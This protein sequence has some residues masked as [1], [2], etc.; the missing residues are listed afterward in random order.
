MQLHKLEYLKCPDCPTSKMIYAQNAF[1]CSSCSKVFGIDNEK[2]SFVNFTGSLTYDSLDAVKSFFKKYPQLYVFLR[3]FFAPVFFERDLHN[4]V[5]ENNPSEKVVVH[6]GS[7]NTRFHKDILNL[8]IIGYGNVNIIADITKIPLQSGSVDAVILDSVLEHV[9]QPDVVTKEVLRILK[10]QGNL[11]VSIPFMMGFHACPDDYYRWTEEGAKILLQ[12][13]KILKLKA[14]G[15]PTSAL[16]WIFQEWLSLV[17]SFGIKPLH[18]FWYIF[19]MVTTWPFKYLDIVL[20]KYEY[21]NKIS[22]AFII[23]CKKNDQ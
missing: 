20:N 5:K 13:F 11:F 17:L 15:G 12:D 6:L 22:S 2:L 14:E 16:L 10:P 8:D 4:F 18:I 7:G 19:L 1:T 21:Q 9:K 3:R 23:I